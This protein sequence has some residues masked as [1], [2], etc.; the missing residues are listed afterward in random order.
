LESARIRSHESQRR[1]GTKSNLQTILSVDHNVCLLI[2]RIGI[3]NTPQIVEPKIESDLDS[4][5]FEEES[6]KKRYRIMS[7]TTICN[8]RKEELNV[9]RQ[10]KK[11]GNQFK[12][13]DA[14]QPKEKF[15]H[16]SRIL[17]MDLVLKSSELI[18]VFRVSNIRKKNILL[19]D[20]KLLQNSKQ[21]CA[22]I[23]TNTGFVYLVNF[24]GKIESVNINEI[25]F[26]KQGNPLTHE[27]FPMEDKHL[28]LIPNLTSKEYFISI[29]ISEDYLG[30]LL[31]VVASNQERVYLVRYSPSSKSGILLSASS[32]LSLRSIIHGDTDYQWYGISGNTL[33]KLSVDERDMITVAST[34]TFD[35]LF[36]ITGAKLI[37]GKLYVWQH[38]NL[39]DYSCKA[40]YESDKLVIDLLEANGCLLALFV[41]GSCCLFKPNLVNNDQWSFIQTIKLGGMCLTGAAVSLNQCVLL[42]LSQKSLFLD[43]SDFTVYELRSVQDEPIVNLLDSCEGQVHTGIEAADMLAW[44]L[45]VY[46]NHRGDYSDII[47]IMLC[48]GNY[49]SIKAMIQSCLSNEEKSKVNSQD[50]MT[51]LD[52]LSTR[53]ACNSI[54]DVKILMSQFL[55]CLK[56]DK[57][58][59]KWL[60]EKVLICKLRDSNTDPEI[61]ET[62]KDGTLTHCPQC[63]AKSMKLT[64]STMLGQC[65]AC[66][67]KM[68][69]VIDSGKIK[70]KLKRS[71]LC[72]SCCIYYS[73]ETTKCFLCCQCLVTPA[74]MIDF[75]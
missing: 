16:L 2:T 7:A 48:S 75:L 21:R 74:E 30:N 11:L 52:Q 24:Q 50:K 61:I 13:S 37:N 54:F 19:A 73:D 47:T 56:P 70:F 63:K 39:Y 46:R 5:D 45:K 26:G 43:T 72:Q 6:D 36:R 17:K 44:A 4:S 25:V 32:T 33:V 58:I 71:I 65:Q 27:P 18:E 23:L 8:E 28:L 29:S 66:N 55:L 60:K 20:L 41:D 38:G 10:I 62:L 12:G 14:M 59:M 42:T 22:L 31:I 69:F 35:S 34:K 40:I 68:A 57:S 49:N 15:S 64:P 53:L 9:Y 67:Q 3:D 51:L 1:R